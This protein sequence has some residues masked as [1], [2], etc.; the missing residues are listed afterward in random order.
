M[1][2]PSPRKKAPEAPAEIDFC[3]MIKQV[4]DGKKVTKLEWNNPSIYFL[5]NNSTL[6]IMQESGKIDTLIVRDADMIG[7]DYVVLKEE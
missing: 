2:T 3:E 7:T 4:L 6:S 1:P 5:L